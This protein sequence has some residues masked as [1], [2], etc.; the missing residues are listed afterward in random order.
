[1]VGIVA[2]L[3]YDFHAAVEVVRLTASPI[4]TV[5]FEL[6]GGMPNMIGIA[7]Q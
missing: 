6:N 1:M 5:T 7:E 2:L 4:V 3:F